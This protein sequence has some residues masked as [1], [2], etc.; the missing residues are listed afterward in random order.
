MAYTYTRIPSMGVRPTLV[1]RTGSLVQLAPRILRA[2]SE[3]ELMM[4]F[5][6]F[7]HLGASLDVFVFSTEPFVGQNVRTN[8]SWYELDLYM[9]ALPSGEGWSV[10]A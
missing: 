3:F 7:V 10:A 8:G 5:E 9:V 4:L 1:S 6:D 2:R